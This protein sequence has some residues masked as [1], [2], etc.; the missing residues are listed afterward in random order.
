MRITYFSGPEDERVMTV[1][2]VKKFSR[3]LQDA[4]NWYADMT[5]DDIED[6]TLEYEIKQLIEDFDRTV[7]A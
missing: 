1:E 3:A 6:R 2:M 4:A 5:P 7:T